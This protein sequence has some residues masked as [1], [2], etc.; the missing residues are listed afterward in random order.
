MATN[1]S[2]FAKLERDRNK[3]AKAAAKRERRQSRE[4]AEAEEV[5]TAAPGEELSAAQL[6]AM[7]EQLHRQ[8]DDEEISFDEF[9]ERKIDLMARIPVD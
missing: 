6:L 3:S 2:T 7:V 5:I 4:K 9:E 1:R 8:L